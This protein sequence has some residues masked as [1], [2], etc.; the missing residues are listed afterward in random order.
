MRYRVANE[1]SVGKKKLSAQL[2]LCCCVH[3]ELA[4]NFVCREHSA[5][6]QREKS[7]P[8]FYA[9]RIIP[10]SINILKENQMWALFYRLPP[11]GG[12]V[13]DSD[14]LVHSKI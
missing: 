5:G 4:Y 2:Q 11:G 3:S 9:I 1:E 13:S 10:C 8:V 12:V 7:P 6:R 14:T